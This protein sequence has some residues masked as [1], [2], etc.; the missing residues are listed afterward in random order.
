MLFPDYLHYLFC[1]NL[2][3]SLYTGEDIMFFAYGEEASR[4]GR[5]FGLYKFNS[6]HLP[7]S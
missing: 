3:L 7:T 5:L 2:S 6:S 1:C 4:M